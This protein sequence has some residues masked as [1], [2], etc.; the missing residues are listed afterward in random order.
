MEKN[1]IIYSVSYNLRQEYRSLQIQLGNILADSSLYLI[2]NS[3]NV[4]DNLKKHI[5]DFYANPQLAKEQKIFHNQTK[6]FKEYLLN[7]QKDTNINLYQNS[8]IIDINNI[9][10]V[11]IE[12]PNLNLSNQ[13]EYF[14]LINN[15]FISYKNLY[16]D[17][18]K[19]YTAIINNL[20]FLC[21]YQ[22]ELIYKNSNL[23][24]ALDY[25]PNWLTCEYIK[26]QLYDLCKNYPSKINAIKNNWLLPELT[27]ADE[28]YLNS[29][30]AKEF[31]KVV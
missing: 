20:G 24:Y 26:R 29:L 21:K 17:I 30:S 9:N 28:Y 7:L 13:S 3:I 10:S 15:V 22:Y 27:E 19:K 8:K 14:L 23:Y 5:N 2:L 12:F 4:L 16:I 31:L 6:K 25:E 18:D 1:N 11:F